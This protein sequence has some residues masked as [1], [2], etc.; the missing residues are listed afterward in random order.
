MFILY[1]RFIVVY[2]TIVSYVF[3]ILFCTTLEVRIC[4]QP[5]YNCI[6]HILY[7]ILYYVLVPI[8]VQYIFIIL[9]LRHKYSA[10]LQHR[11]NW[12]QPPLPTARRPSRANGGAPIP[13]PANAGPSIPPTSHQRLIQSI[14]PIQPVAN[15]PAHKSQFLPENPRPILI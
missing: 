2:S 13:A 7:T 1:V 14:C 3:F 11:S 15:Q 10:P 8:C 4:V 6:V 5:W 9:L 12:C